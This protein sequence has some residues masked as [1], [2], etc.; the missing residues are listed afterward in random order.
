MILGGIQW[1]AGLEL[2]DYAH[3]NNYSG[4]IALFGA[5]EM[6]KSWQNTM[7]LNYFI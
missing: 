3:N 7:I 5:M 1:A 2:I 6:K 4:K